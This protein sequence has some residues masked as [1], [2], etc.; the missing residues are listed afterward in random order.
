[1]QR[2]LDTPNLLTDINGIEIVFWEFKMIKSK[3]ALAA[4]FALA[5][6]IAH[7]SASS[8]VED[9]NDTGAGA[10]GWTAIDHLTFDYSSQYS[11]TG[12]KTGGY[13]A[14]GETNPLGGTGYFVAPSTSAFHGD[15]STYVGG[16]LSFDIKVFEGTK[17]NYFDDNDVMISGNGSTLL[18]ATHINPAEAPGDGW[19]HFSIALTTAN[20][21]SNL[22]TVLANVSNF[23]L[24][25]E[26]I[27]GVE[28]EG[29]DN[30]T[31]T[32]AVPEPSTWAMMILGFCGVGFMAY[33]R[34]SNPAMLE[35]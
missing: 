17:L 27:D 13:L 4:A 3:I 7:A 34:K 1:V 32:T 29:I 35:A 5:L 10:N 6:P 14:G 19:V 2:Q 30:V 18:F 20:F 11:A 31:L 25:G 33:R 15:L 16:T 12:G 26:F 21:G 9:F 8:I 23:E 28:K 22:A 24:R